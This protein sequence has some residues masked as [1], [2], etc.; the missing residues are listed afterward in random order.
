MLKYIIWIFAFLSLYIALVWLNFLYLY[1]GSKKKEKLKDYPLITIAVPAFNE[2]K[3]ILKTLRSILHLSYPQK[4]IEIIVINDGS[5]DKTSTVVEK[6]VKKYKNIKLINQENKGKAESLN[7]ALKIASGEYFACLDADSTITRNSV[8]LMLHSFSEHKTAAVI[9]ALKVKD[10][11]NLYEKLQRFEYI[12]AIL[13]R[14]LKAN[15]NTLAMTPGVLS[16]Y[17]TK[18]LKKVGGFDK[19]NMTEDFE[20]AMRLKYYGYNIRIET[21]SFTYTNVPNN[22]SSFLRQRVR[23]FRGFMY[24]HLKYKKMFF[25]KKYGLLGYFQLPLNIIGV[26]SLLISMSIITFYA[27][28]KIAEFFIRVFKIDGYLTTYVIKL[29]SFK[30]LLLSHNTKIMLPIYIA[31]ISGIYLFYLAHK[32]SK[33]KIKYPISA[34]TYFVIYPYLVLFHWVSAISQEILKIKRKW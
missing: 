12:I 5:T 3:T 32:Q 14:K 6:F 28:S 25:N 11:K 29:P 10:S 23:W 31:S 34:L 21:N 8:E 2:E 17:K 16:I 26:F 20:I 22:F 30:E 13:M 18:I 4:N 24:N 15:I 9:S 7:Q 27:V 33:E 19:D 1:N